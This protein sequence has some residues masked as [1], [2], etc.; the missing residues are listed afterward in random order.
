MT[1]T[2]KPATFTWEGDVLRPASPFM[3]RLADR[4]MVIGET[5]M[6]VE[7]HDRSMNSHRHYFAMVH[8]G[9]QNLPEAYADAP[10]AQSSEHLR[11]YALIKTGYCDS[12]SL[13]CTNKAEAQRVAAFVRPTTPYGLVLVKDAVVTRYEAKSQAVKA[14]GRKDFQASKDA[15]LNFIEDL[16]GVE[17]EAL[18]KAEAA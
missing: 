2:L 12:H 10:W 9:W 4:Q 3:A 15:V 5:Y 8:E 1:D 11:A 17:R 16:I 14:M 6:L 13:V 7:H 18:R